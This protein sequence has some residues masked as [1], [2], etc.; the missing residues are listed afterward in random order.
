M[1]PRWKRLS[2]ALRLALPLW[3]FAGLAGAATIDNFEGGDPSTLLANSAT[4]RALE[5]SDPNQGTGES[6]FTSR[7]LT[8]EWESGG[9]TVTGSF[10]NTPPRFHC[11]SAGATGTCELDYRGGGLHDLT[12]EVFRISSATNDEITGTLVVDDSTFSVSR[13]FLL[14]GGG[15]TLSFNSLL[16]PGAPLTWT[17]RRSVDWQ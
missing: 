2:G 9:A 8:V 11:G 12:D 3:A 16:T 14:T 1:K 4:P 15:L 17:S 5:T 6:I 10:D 13:Q 7:T